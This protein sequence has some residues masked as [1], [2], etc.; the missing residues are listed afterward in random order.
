MTCKDSTLTA[1]SSSTLY[2]TLAASSASRT[3]AVA[4]LVASSASR[5][6][7]AICASTLATITRNDSTLAAASAS[8]FATLAASSASRVP[9]IFVLPSPLLL[10]WPPLPLSHALLHLLFPSPR[11]FLAIP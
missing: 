10:L 1:A 8:M 4:T 5:T 11:V 9:L 3:L 6:L 2:A 7:P